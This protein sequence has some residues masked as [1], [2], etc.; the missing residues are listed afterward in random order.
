MSTKARNIAAV[1]LQ[2]ENY[3][4]II[5]QH[6]F[7][8]GCAMPD[9]S[10]GYDDA[11]FKNL[12][13]TLAGEGK[14]KGNGGQVLDMIKLAEKLNSSKF[15]TKNPQSAVLVNTLQSEIIRLARQVEINNRSM[16]AP[17]EGKLNIWNSVDITNPGTQGN[18][19]SITDLDGTIICQVG[20]GTY[21]AEGCK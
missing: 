19:S 3:A 18:E 7:E 20:N 1:E 11:D 12:I 6:C 4:K 15:A 9:P 8:Q 21:N 14:I 17:G 16:H 10:T 5:N 2:I 13:A